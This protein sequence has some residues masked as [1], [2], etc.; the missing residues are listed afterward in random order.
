[1]MTVSVLFF[2]TA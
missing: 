1:M 2:M